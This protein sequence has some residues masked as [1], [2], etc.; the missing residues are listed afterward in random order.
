MAREAVGNIKGLAAAERRA[1]AKLFQRRIDREEIVSLDL[2]RE[3]FQL[4]QSLRRKMGI[5]IDRQGNVVE[6]VLGT[7]EVIYLPDLGR[8]RM[9][10]GRLRNLRLI[11]TDLS[12]VDGATP[13]IPSD[14][15]ADLEKLRF[16]MVVA[17]GSAKNRVPVTYAHLSPQHG[18]AEEAASVTESA[19]DLGQLSL[20][21]DGFISEL[22]IELSRTVETLTRSS[23]PGAVLVGV[24]EPG[25]SRTPT[26]SMTELKE[27]V[28][29]AGVDVLDTV[30]Q[31]RKIDPRTFMGSGKLEE[32]VLRCLRLG[33][34]IVIFDAELKP[35]QWRAITNA[36]DLKV[37]DRSM[38]ILD[39]FA[40]RAQS[41]EGRL[42]V[43]LA[44]LRYNLPRL[45]EKD[46]GLSRLVGGIG[47]RGPGETKLEVGRRRIRERI[48]EIE[49]RLGKVRADRELRRG[50]RRE[51]GVSVVAVVG[52]TNVGKSSLFNLLT[53]SGVLAENKLFATLDPNR[54]KVFLGKPGE[55]GPEAVLSDTVGFIH[56]LPK[57]LETAFQATLEELEEAELL[58]HVVDAADEAALEKHAAVRATLEK[59]GLAE[60]PELVVVNKIDLVEGSSADELCSQLNGIGVS[61]LR[62]TNI[63]G[64]LAEIRARVVAGAPAP[65]APSEADA[66][67]E[68]W[69]ISR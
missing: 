59:M 48:T 8:Y 60:R 18:S 4:S 21:F 68:P 7:K 17:I 16:D 62:K 40:Q 43:E 63:D 67:P 65:R 57:E 44:Q 53:R 10:A 36:T 2:A 54:R 31:R 56:D 51:Q 22:E 5:L 28:R 23:R 46:A 33:A 20:D 66:P 34:E 41:S 25:F 61:V 11:F 38:V 49:R 26:A 35:S 47:G 15:Y 6:V 52:Y 30:T 50:R 19:P 24:Y 37:L 29:T 64:L 12:A 3:L 14:I 32:V 42:Q 69:R 45:V 9:G 55:R 58:L 39:I 1:I 13:R 27:L